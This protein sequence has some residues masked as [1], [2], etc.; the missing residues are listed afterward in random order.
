M[1]IIKATDELLN[2][3]LKRSDLISNHFRYFQSRPTSIIKN[4][5]ITIIGLEDNKPIAYGHIDYE[6]YNWL[7]ICIL[8]GYQGK[9]YG[10]QMMNELI[11]YADENKLELRLSVDKDNLH[12]VSLYR[13]YNFIEYKSTET[14]IYMK[15]DII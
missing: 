3:F 12:A 15:R 10:T 11:K 4:H 2:Q 7:G 9:G 6:T 14:V 8:N 13:K 5:L 1:L